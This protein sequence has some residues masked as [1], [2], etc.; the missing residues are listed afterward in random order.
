MTRKQ[1][2]LKFKKYYDL[3][4]DDIEVTITEEELVDA[5]KVLDKQKIQIINLKTGAEVIPAQSF[6]EIVERHCGED[7][8]VIY[9]L[10]PRS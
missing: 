7:V 6:I 3:I 4:E 5:K 10:K 9:Y 1:A 2:V 8:Y